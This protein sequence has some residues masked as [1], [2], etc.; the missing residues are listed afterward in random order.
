MAAVTLMRQGTSSRERAV[1]AFEH[2]MAHRNALGVIGFQKGFTPQTGSTAKPIKPRPPL[3]H[4]SVAPYFIDPPG[5]DRPA[6]K[7][8]LNHQQ[9]HD[10]A[11]RNLPDQYGWRYYNTLVIQPQPPPPQPPVPPLEF[12]TPQ[13]VRYGLRIGGNLIDTNFANRWQASWWTF[14]NWMEHYVGSKSITPPPSPKP[15]PQWTFPFW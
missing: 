12:P 15:A 9:A 5:G 7:W 14:Q 1:F 8:S 3:S 4:Y 6:N 13:Q 2:A 10:D 11:L